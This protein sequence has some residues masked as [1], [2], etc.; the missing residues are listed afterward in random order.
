MLIPSYLENT[1]EE[2]CNQLATSVMGMGTGGGGGGIGSIY[3]PF[4][5]GSPPDLAEIS[6][7]FSL[8]RREKKETGE[9]GWQRTSSTS[10]YTVCGMV[11]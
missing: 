4:L 5:L 2:W 11:W 7:P 3:L 10:L 1:R 9:E 6:V 8:D